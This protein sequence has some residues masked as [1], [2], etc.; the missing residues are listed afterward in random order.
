MPN[1]IITTITFS[2]FYFTARS[3]STFLFKPMGENRAAFMEKGIEHSSR[4]SPK[5]RPQFENAIFQIFGFRLAKSMSVR[6]EKSDAPQRFLPE[7]SR[8]SIQVFF[9]RSISVHIFVEAYLH[10]DHR[11]DTNDFTIR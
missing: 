9:H 2:A 3:F 5:R 10:S 4:I 8:Q 1:A 7:F 6:F 11:F